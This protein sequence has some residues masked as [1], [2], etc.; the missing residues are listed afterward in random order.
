MH[1][2]AQ[3]QGAT[4]GMNRNR[5][6]VTLTVTLTLLL[7]SLAA[8]AQNSVPPT[9]RQAMTMPQYAAKLARGASRVPHSVQ[10]NASYRRANPR[11]RNSRGWLPQDTEVYDNGPINGTTDAWNINFGFVVSDSFTV[12]TNGATVTGLTFG[13]WTFAGDVAQ[14]VEISITSSE[15]GGTTY[16]DNVVNVTQSN[17]SGNQ[18]GYNVCTETSANFNGVALN[19]GTYWVNLQ[20]AV[21]NDGDPLFWDENSGAGCGSNG[22]PSQASQTST[23]TIPSEAFTILGTTNSNNC[24]FPPCPVC[25]SDDPQDGFSI[26][27]NFTANGETPAGLAIDEAGN[28]YGAIYAG[29][30]NG[31][32]SAYKLASVHGNWIFDPLYSFLGGSAGQNP[33]GAI[34]GPEQAFYGVA[35]GG[36]QNCGSSGADYCGVVYRL[37]PSPTVCLTALCSWT[38]TVLYQFLGD[39]DG[40][41]PAGDLVFDH[42]GNVYGTTIKGGLYGQGTVYELTPTNGGW[43]ERVIHSFGGGSDGAQPNSLLLGED[44]NLYGATYYGGAGGGGVIFQLTPSGDTWTETIISNFGGCA[45]SGNCGYYIPRLLQ[46]SA[47][48]FYGIAEYSMQVCPYGNCFLYYFDEIFSMSPSATGWQFTTVDTTYNEYCVQFGTWC[49]DQGYAF[50]DGLSV[51]A[52]GNLYGTSNSVEFAYGDQYFY[53]TYVFKQLGAYQQRVLVSFAGDDFG[54]VEVSPNGNLYGITGACGNSQGT[55]WQLT[56]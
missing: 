13:A 42:A 36:N 55:V 25:V 1:S 39:P 43:S 46:Q 15:F 12:P 54:D 29:G 34:L 26:I 40:W 48:N 56:P 17:C 16:F 24:E 8:Q 32:G 2:N 4:F 30:D 18:Y 53:I 37:R 6:V 31:L 11:G 52:A 3:Y 21:V 9:A 23:G 20:N 22:C 27:H 38:E 51:D 50:F 44:G 10:P 33:S 45:G 19:A 28:L 14:T 41:G 35:S 7:L 47:G 49:Y 5:V